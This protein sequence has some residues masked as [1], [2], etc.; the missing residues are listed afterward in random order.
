MTT[1]SAVHAFHSALTVQEHADST[2]D[3]VLG[4]P[5]ARR[6]LD[7]SYSSFITEIFD[8]WSPNRR[9]TFSVTVTIASEL[10]GH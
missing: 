5:R 7:G 1:V 4:T 2:D 3:I 10:T 6:T 9:R 8:K